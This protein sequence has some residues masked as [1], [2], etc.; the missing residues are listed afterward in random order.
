ML[1]GKYFFLENCRN[2][3]FLKVSD[4]YRFKSTCFNNIGGYD[5]VDLIYII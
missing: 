5:E 1:Q 2:A 4:I 3:E